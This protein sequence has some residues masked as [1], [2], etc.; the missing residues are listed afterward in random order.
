MWGRPVG[1]FWVLLIGLE[2]KS[3]PTWRCFEKP[4]QCRLWNVLRDNWPL[5][6]YIYK[7]VEKIVG[8]QCRATCLMGRYKMASAWQ[9]LCMHQLSVFG[10][11][12]ARRR[13]MFWQG[14]CHTMIGCQ[15]LQIRSLLPCQPVEFLQSTLEKHI[16]ILIPKGRPAS[17][18][19]PGL[20][21]NRRA[22]ILLLLPIGVLTTSGGR[23]VGWAA[24]PQPIASIYMVY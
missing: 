3:Q 10:Y 8:S 9:P 14:Q 18:C 12:W 21:M 7:G 13:G 11:C 16:N 20:W 6:F 15:E 2:H 5:H 22:V 19:L 4:F 17:V 23:Q 24:L 1:A